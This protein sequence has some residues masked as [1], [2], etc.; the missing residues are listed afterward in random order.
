MKNNYHTQSGGMGWQ[1]YYRLA[2][3]APSFIVRHIY[4]TKW[5]RAINN[6]TLLLVKKKVKGFESGFDVLEPENSPD[7]GP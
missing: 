6:K 1:S 5:V 2:D 4:S 3:L 7:P